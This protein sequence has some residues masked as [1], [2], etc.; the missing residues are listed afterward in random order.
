MLSFTLTILAQTDTETLFQ[1]KPP[2][3]RPA[4]FV[5]SM[6]PCIAGV[7]YQYGEGWNVSEATLEEVRKIMKEAHQKVPTYKSEVR[8]LEIDLMNASTEE[9]YEDY[10]RLLRALSE[11]KI[12]ASLFHEELVKKARKTFSKQDLIILDKFILDNQEVFLA[13]NKLH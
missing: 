8:A 13:A 1:E 12:E 3:K 2:I 6:P 4:I 9:R 10:E 11:L 7:A 5:A